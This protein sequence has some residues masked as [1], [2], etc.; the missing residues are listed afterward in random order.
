MKALPRV[1][2]VEDDQHIAGAIIYTLKSSYSVD[3]VA[4][5][6]LAIFKAGSSEYDLVLLDLNLPDINGLDVCRKL[7]SR[8]FIAPIFILSGENKAV[9]KIMLLD[10]GANDYLCKPFT[11]GELK[12]R[13]RVLLRSRLDPKS[14]W[15]EPILSSGEVCLNR[16]TCTVI[17]AGKEIRLRRKEF[18]LLACLMENVGK[19][20]NRK[21]LIARAWEDCYVWTN[22]LDVH[23]KFLR[24]KFDKPFTE[25]LIRTVHGR[26][27]MF[28]G[29]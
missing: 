8:G 16:D 7:R 25:K 20:V 13:M 26:G 9:T 11:V 29:G 6:K 17:R 27:Y 23:I 18:D 12:A 5:G 15:P 21:E 1:L 14:V 4:S 19:V 22:T 10:S 2:L 3:H 24:D 28:Y